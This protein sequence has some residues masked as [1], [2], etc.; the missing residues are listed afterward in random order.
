MMPLFAANGYCG[1][2]TLVGEGLCFSL[3]LFVQ[4]MFQMTAIEQSMEE[5]G[6]NV[7]TVFFFYTDRVASSCILFISVIIFLDK[8]LI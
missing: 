6:H 2:Q 7:F 4:C 1:L 5:D 8:Y 3:F